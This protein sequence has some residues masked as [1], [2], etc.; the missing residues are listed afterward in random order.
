MIDLRK[1]KNDFE[2]ILV[3][4][5]DYPFY[6]NSENLISQW[7]EAKRDIINLFGGE[8][9]LRSKEPVKIF[10]TEEQRDK[11]FEEFLQA[12]DEN[13]ILTEEFELFLRVNKDG[14]FDNKVMLP[15]PSFNIPLGSKLS[16]SFKKFLN[17]NEI[18]RW[19]QDLSLIHI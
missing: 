8:L 7:L 12:L 18:V 19:A 9:V 6:L 16:K 10:L 1:L 3:H 2:S 4:S 11:R 14:F 5:Q 13:G 17:S 15:Y